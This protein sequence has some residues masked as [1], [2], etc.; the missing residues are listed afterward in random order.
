[1]GRRMR[2]FF[3]CPNRCISGALLEKLRIFANENGSRA[4]GT[5]F[6]VEG[7]EGPLSNTPKIR[8]DRVTAMVGQMIPIPNYISLPTRF[9]FSE[10]VPVHRVAGSHL[11][12]VYVYY[13][14]L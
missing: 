6:K 2:F 11:G 1:M 14:Q 8:K 4:R 5:N 13:P 9:I 7:L 10:V 3:D 12:V